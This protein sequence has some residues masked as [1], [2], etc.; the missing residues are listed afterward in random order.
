MLSGQ[1]LQQ[2]LVLGPWSWVDFSD[3]LQVVLPCGGWGLVGGIEGISLGVWGLNCFALLVLVFPFGLVLKF[4][5]AYVCQF[6]RHSPE[7]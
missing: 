2:L 1:L 3:Q 5:R 7:T 6:C 4:L